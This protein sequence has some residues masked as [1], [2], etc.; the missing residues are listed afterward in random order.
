ML[1]PATSPLETPP[2]KRVDA[3]PLPR[4]ASTDVEVSPRDSVEIVGVAVRL[5]SH[6]SQ[7]PPWQCPTP[8]ASFPETFREF[9]DDD[10]P[11]G[12]TTASQQP[13]QDASTEQTKQ[14]DA[15]VENKNQDEGLAQPS[16]GSEG[17]ETRS[18]EPLL[19]T[20]GQAHEQSQQDGKNGDG[21]NGADDGDKKDAPEP[22]PPTPAAQQ[23]W[24]IPVDTASVTKPLDNIY[25]NGCY[26]Q[27]LA[28]TAVCHICYLT[29]CFLP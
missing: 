8:I 13:S 29:L 10:L 17:K 19:E 5:P 23:Q 11:L 7:T 24:K 16:T 25:Q 27:L 20:N 9:K 21:K 28:S 4:A 14:A 12:Q 22:P 18:P 6:D 15:A 1:V 2:P 26:W 3:S